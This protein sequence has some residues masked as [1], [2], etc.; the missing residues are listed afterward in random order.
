MLGQLRKGGRAQEMEKKRLDRQR[1]EERLRR[2]E[3]RLPRG[4]TNPRDEDERPWAWDDAIEPDEGRR[5]GTLA[6]PERGRED[7]PDWVI[8]KFEDVDFGPFTL[9]EVWDDLNEV[10]KLAEKMGWGPTAPEI[11]EQEA[12]S[13]EAIH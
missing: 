9:A 5:R 8:E 2:R 11:T 1:K 6:G 4:W 10:V 12:V 7:I 13:P 3:E